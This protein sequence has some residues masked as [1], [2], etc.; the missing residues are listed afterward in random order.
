MDHL[1]GFGSLRIQ[2]D[3]VSNLRSWMTS[4]DRTLP[5]FDLPEHLDNIEPA[6]RE[7]FQELWKASQVTDF[8]SAKLETS[9]FLWRISLLKEMNLYQAIIQNLRATIKGKGK[10]RRGEKIATKTRTQIFEIYETIYPQDAVQ[11]T[12]TF[13]KKQTRARP[14]LVLQQH[15]QNEGFL[16][17]FPSLSDA[18]ITGT[19]RIEVLVEV[20]DLL[21]PDFRAERLRV[22]SAVVND[23][24]SGQTP[25]KAEM[26]I[27]ERW[28]RADCQAMRIEAIRSNNSALLARFERYPVEGL[29][30]SVEE[31]DELQGMDPLEKEEL[32]A[33]RFDHKRHDPRV[34]GRLRSESR[35]NPT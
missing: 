30:E 13:N 6:K 26:H 23:L 28:S 4:D 27:L 35:Q 15:Y 10:L 9:A 22:Y 20:L 32:L 8:R 29:Y 5:A 11:R 34:G 21:R 31:R 18:E 12:N 1:L 7:T 17:M 25:G 16:A 33:R 3:F 2:Q 14:Y 24:Y 19:S